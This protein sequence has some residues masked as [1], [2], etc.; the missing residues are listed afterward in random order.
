MTLKILIVLC[1]VLGIGLMA[2]WFLVPRFLEQP[3]YIII[4][5]ES[6]FEIRRYEAMLL[7]SVNVS[8]D[9][10]S[11]L[12]KGFRP[13][14]SYIGGKKRD[15]VKISMTAPVFQAVGENQE[16]WI[17]SFSM[18][19]KYTKASLP[20]PSDKGLFSEELNPS[21]AAVIRF[22][23]KANEKMLLEKTE[24]LFDWLQ[25]TDYLITSKPKYLFYND[26]S[27]PGFLRR[28]EVVVL[29]K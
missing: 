2:A 23:G 16:D 9:Q 27:T 24:A 7:K 12:R 11:S 25:D 18:P 21:K 10:Y 14:A 26:P 17:I 6:E 1:C 29:I 3:S 20:H 5:K 4:K 8:G 15:G 28:N 19:S 22:N 13:L